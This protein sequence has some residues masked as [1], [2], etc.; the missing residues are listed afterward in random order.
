MDEALF[1]SPGI[2]EYE[3]S[4]VY[5][6]GNLHDVIFNKATF[7]DQ[8]GRV[9]GLVG[10]ILDL[11]ERKKAEKALIAAEEKFR[12]LVEQSLVGIYIIQDGKFVY[13]N[14]KM[15][16]IFGYSREELIS[17]ISH[18]DLTADDDRPMAAEN[19]RKRVQGEAQSMQY[20]F[21]GLR[22][23]GTIRHIEVYGTSTVYDGSPAVIGT[24]LDIT[25]RKKTEYALRESE[26]RFSRIFSQN[27]D[28]IILFR[29]DS[30]QIIDANPAAAALTGY[31]KEEL[32]ILSPFSFI[33][34][35]DFEKLI[36]KIPLDNTHV[37]Q[38]LRA[39][40]VKKDGTMLAVSIRAKVLQMR[41]EYV[42]YCSIRDMSE[43]YR[44]EDEVRNTQAKLIQTNKMTSIG[45]LASSVA[46][47]INNPNNCI[48][49]NADMLADVW[50]DAEPLLEKIYADQ[51]GF[52]LRGIPFKQMQKVAPRL[53]NGITE[54]SRRITAIVNNMKDFVRE[55]KSGP[56]GSVE[57]NQ[58]I[59]NAATI[60]WHHIHV[61][62]DKFHMDL[63][64]SLPQAIGNWQQIEQV[65]INLMMNALQSLADKSAA[66]EVS[67][68]FDPESEEIAIVVR[69]EGKGMDREVMERLREPFFTTKLAEGGTGL[70]LYISDSIIKEHKGSLLFDS[71]PGRGTTATITLPRRHG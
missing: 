39:T 10:V 4:I 28:A 63:C 62:T 12:G 33:E 27:D 69:D 50:Y 20:E 36:E 47:E 23:N 65:V 68:A 55:D 16:E 17:G 43:K 1:T 70:G 54:G 51:G 38:L 3:A 66:V 22:K 67:T 14:P 34:P 53:L 6:D 24:L 15:A 35:E 9:I 29:L 57:V 41:D 46:H 58:L 19:V 61:Y 31:S 37:F 42:I 44:L 30:F 11:T 49:V 52:L 25:A 32:T 48:S 56:N 59:R 5:A 18:L 45:M 2:Q 40:A 8:G 13:V 21:R 60:L 26:D 71:T 64:E 7:T